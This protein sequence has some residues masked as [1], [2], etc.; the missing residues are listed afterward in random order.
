MLVSCAGNATETGYDT[1]S[2][3]TVSEENTVANRED[4]DGNTKVNISELIGEHAE[5][6]VEEN[7]E[8]AT[9]EIT[10]EITAENITENTTENITENIPEKFLLGDEQTEK[11]LP[12]TEGKRV[13][14]FTNQTGIVGAGKLFKRDADG[15][16]DNAEEFALRLDV[17]FSETEVTGEHILDFLMENGVNVTAV[18]CPE[19]GFRGDADAGESVSDS[20]DDRTGVPVYS[21]YGVSNPYSQER[22]ELFDTLIV[23]IQ[24]VGVRYYTYYITMSQFMNVCAVS[25]KEVII[26]DR[27]DPNGFYVDGPVLRDGF[28]SGV[29]SLPLPV[30]H[31][32]T[33][34][35][36]GLMINGE[37]WLDSGAS[38]NLTVITCSGYDR[39]DL[40]LL[41]IAP[42]PNLKDMR[43]I[44]LYP[45]T[46]YFENTAVSVGRGT[47][48]PFEIYGSPYLSGSEEFGYVFTPVSM[49][50]AVSPPFMGQEC[51]GRSLMEKSADKLI[52]EGINIG[53]LIDIYSEMNSSRGDISF[54]GSP[55]GS[56]RYWIDLLMGTDEIRKMIIEGNLPADIKASWKEDVEGF[57]TLREKYLLYPEIID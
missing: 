7:P 27:P 3:V 24:D 1:G 51:F 26:L 28:R 23:D 39:N 34:G 56:G 40:Y 4:A 16:I 43:A 15:T 9:S 47:E 8:E 25:G 53:Y 33:I 2:A 37:G 31:G 38:C 20:I 35:E 19:H 17:P 11:Y 41:D 5:E 44:Y 36:L 49:T 12:L 45:S 21:L 18:F 14:V 13:A 55:D 6:A 22:M 30:V 54:F 57:K 52:D 46:C 10:S 42:S 50:G 29:G 48:H 32:M